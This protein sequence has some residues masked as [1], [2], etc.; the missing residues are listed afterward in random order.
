MTHA[1][2]TDR[3]SFAPF[4]RHAFFTEVNRWIVER[5]VEPGRKLIVDLGCG[6]G[7]VTKL[8][9]DRLGNGSD[10]RVIG[11]DP[12]PSAL[13]RARAVVSARVA[14]FLEGSA[15]CLSRLV[16]RADV[17]LF[18]NA[19]HLVPDKGAVIAEVRKVLRRG[20]VFGFNT[21]FFAG[22][23]PEGTAGFWRRWI[24]RSVQWLRERG[25]AVQ[26]T[27]ADRATA[28]QWLSPEDYARL[29]VSA[30]FAEPLMERVVVDMTPESLHDIGHFS[31]F[32]EGALPGVPLEL[33]A[34]ALDQ[35]LDRTL[36]ELGITAV[37]RTWLEVV[38]E[39]A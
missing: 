6:P 8:I 20:G 24:V 25:V 22:A 14:E 37:P 13:A 35:G 39:A 17:V 18:L 5:V 29:C 1:R 10:A 7:A 3:F 2:E 33:G 38:A 30:G 31:L 19:I 4:T 12:E 16:K 15:E 26:H 9:V 34:Q 32:I 11:I 28:M 23:Y 27:H 36:D 21:T